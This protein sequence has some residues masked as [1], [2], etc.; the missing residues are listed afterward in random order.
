MLEKALQKYKNNSIEAAQ[1]IEELIDIARKIRDSEKE[2]EALGMSPDEIAFYDALAVNGS[3]REVMGDDQL[4]KLAALLVKRVRAN[5]TVDW[6]L[7]QDAQARLRIEVKRLLREYGYP[8]DEQ[9]IATELVLE[10]ASLFGNE[11]AG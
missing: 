8:P 10:Q 6:T 1:I 3:A 2:A 11:W 9:K 7:R 4:R 5:V